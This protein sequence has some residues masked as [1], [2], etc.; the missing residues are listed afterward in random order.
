MTPTSAPIANVMQVIGKLSTGEYA[1]EP[2][3]CFCGADPSRDTE[4][5]RFDRY[6]IP[7]R[8]VMCEDCLLIRAN[9]R[10]TAE[11]Y[12]RFY[13]DEYR[14]IYDGFPYGERWAD[15][16]LSFDMQVAKALSTKTV[17]TELEVP[18]PANGV[19]VD[20]GSN[21]G[22]GL[23][24]F[25]EDGHT[26]YGVEWDQSGRDYAN[27]RG[28]PTV[29]SI[30]ELIAKGVQADL[31][32]MHDVIEHFLDL[33]AEIL[34]LKQILAPNGRIFLYTPGLL[35]TPPSRVFQNAHTW[36][37]IGETLD[38]V[39]MTLGFYADFLDDQ[40]IGIYS[41]VGPEKI[42]T[43]KPVH[44]RPYMLEHLR[45]EERRAV[46]PVRTRC[47]FG[48]RETLAN[49]KKNL[50]YKLPDISTLLKSRT[51]PA[52]VI[53]AG[54]SVDGQVEEIRRLQADGVAVIAIDRMYPWAVQHGLTVDYVVS[55]DATPG[56]EDG[57]THL[58]D[59]TTHLLV[60]TGYP[61][62]IERM[63]DVPNTYLF[64]GMAGALKDA[65]TV[66][67]EA[68]YGKLVIIATGGSVV[69][70]SMYIALTLGFS[71]VHLFGF[72]CMV[73]D[74]G[75][76]Y[77]TGVAGESVPRSYFTVEV[78][79]EK[80]LT[81]TTFLAF[82]QQFFRMVGV[83][84]KNGLLKA[85]DIHGESLVNKMFEVTHDQDEAALA[86]HVVMSSH[87]TLPKEL[88]NG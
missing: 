47:K 26:V 51:G 69:L 14:K 5:T 78:G 81:C 46:P 25:Q 65:E 20:I 29:A 83:A 53:G 16:Q 62:L 74:E 22:G 18:F 73:P 38:Y 6:T 86:A 67:R 71:H 49:L 84:A 41:Y 15:P 32:T 19:V 23:A 72:D 44:W 2:S 52:L 50:A 42:Q 7:H 87:P 77:S 13:N 88:V 27:A 60:A 17:L 11:A 68:G 80:V 82:A 36:Q 76:G 3:R 59:G 24:T 64:S 33:R 48:D 21:K 45:Q 31:I 58:Q 70:G 4:V 30:D 1:T 35:A 34:K 79:E 63:K 28:I 56:V 10:M 43:I 39:M 12:G 57:F 54:P 8:M 75:H 55:L 37:F 61:P 9:P 85:V 66:W 40:I